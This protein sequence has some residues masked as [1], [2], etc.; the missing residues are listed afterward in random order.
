LFSFGAYLGAVVRPTSNP[1]LYGLLGLLGIFAPGLLAMTAVLPYWSAL[2]ANRP[3]QAALKGI[4]ASVVGVLIAALY[5]PLWVS[6][7][8]TAIDFCLALCA[9]ALLAVWKVQP[10]LVVVA[11]AAISV[12]QHYW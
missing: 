10:W 1:L 6:T 7:I 4:N 2:R 11:I 12:L 8:N 5:R 3:V 9:F